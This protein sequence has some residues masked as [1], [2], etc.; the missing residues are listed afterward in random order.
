VSAQ[1]SCGSACRGV[2]VGKHGRENED[3]FAEYSKH[4]HALPWKKNYKM[5]I[6]TTMKIVHIYLCFTLF[7]RFKIYNYFIM[8]VASIIYVGYNIIMS[9]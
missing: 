8:T 5:F 7:I 1:G 9:Y 3:F 4:A 2:R 6:I